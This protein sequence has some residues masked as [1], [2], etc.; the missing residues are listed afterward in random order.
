MRAGLGGLRLAHAEAAA[1]EAALRT[2]AT[3]G[4]QGHPRMPG[5]VRNLA[6]VIL[7]DVAVAMTQP[8]A[9]AL[10][11]CSLITPLL[12]V[13]LMVTSGSVQH[14]PLQAALFTRWLEGGAAT[15]YSFASVQACMCHSIRMPFVLSACGLLCHAQ[16]NEK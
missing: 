16:H 6:A 3:G 14:L 11:K 7:R 5:G 9:H 10:A 13:G 2:A 1:Q 12:E 4:A 8:V 15:G